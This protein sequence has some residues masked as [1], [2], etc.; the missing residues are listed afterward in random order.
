MLQNYVLQ[1]A[2]R[3]KDYAKLFLGFTFLLHKRRVFNNLVTK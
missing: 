2:M 1:I 3:S